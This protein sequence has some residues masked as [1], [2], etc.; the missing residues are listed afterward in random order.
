MIVRATWLPIAA[1]TSLAIVAFFLPMTYGFWHGYDDPLMLSSAN[2]NWFDYDQSINRPFVPLGPTI[3]LHL[4]PNRIDGFVW[5]TVALRIGTGAALYSILRQLLRGSTAVPCIAATL[6]IVNPSEPG[7]FLVVA[8]Q[9]YEFTVF[10]LTAAIALYIF[11][12]RRAVRLLLVVS[13]ILLGLALLTYEAAYP[14][15]AAIPVVLLVAVSRRNHWLAWAYA[16]WGVTAVLA[17]RLLAFLVATPNSYQLETTGAP[18]RSVSQL[19]DN[20]VTQV[21]PALA[22]FQVSPGEQRY[23]AYG[24]AAAVVAMVAVLFAGKI[25]IR[26]SFRHM[27]GIGTVASALVFALSII[28]YFKFPYVLRTQFFAA[29]AQAAFW[30]FALAFT[31]SFLW[32]RL[33]RASMVLGTGVLVLLATTSST[34]AQANS[35]NAGTSMDFTK[36]VYIYQQVHTAAPK[37]VPGTLILFVVNDFK[38][39][40]FG[41][42]YNVSELTKVAVGEDGVV[43]AKDP[44]GW[45]PLYSP[46]GVLY[47]DA[48]VIGRPAGKSQYKYSEVVAFDLQ[49]N[50]QVTLL[51]EFPDWLLPEGVSASGYDP[52]ARIETEGEDPLRFMQY[53]AWMKPYQVPP[54]QATDIVEPASRVR[55]GDGWYPLETYKGQTFRWV[56]NDAEIMVSGSGHGPQVI[57]LQLEPGARPKG[58]PLDLQV[59]GTEGG[60]VTEY[61]VSGPSTVSIEVPAVPTLFR[62]RLHVEDS[63]VPTGADPRTLNF[64]VFR[65]SETTAS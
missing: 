3:A 23:L 36:L 56:N 4:S 25:P 39:V 55:L 8:L 10:L 18:V 27:L 60:S 46:D 50:G 48:D 11:S 49:P 28:P 44:L 65:I 7:R 63:A 37:L 47:G 53:S 13:L 2:L 59:L 54:L 40:P 38:S 26:K 16:W 29:P 57:N 15:A 51:K 42:N 45:Q 1:L 33:Q 24:A 20:I 19:V 35:I 32:P 41:V 30:A 22:F 9:A 14:I 5:L 61:S 17:I 64:R 12:Y 58:Q 62:Y 52:T 21:R 6:Y 43:S 31:V 34:F